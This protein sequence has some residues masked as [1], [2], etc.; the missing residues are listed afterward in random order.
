M[1]ELIEDRIKYGLHEYGDNP[2][3]FSHMPHWLIY[4]LSDGTIK[5]KFGSED[6]WYLLVRTPTGDVMVGPDDYLVRGE[7]GNVLVEKANNS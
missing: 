5:P 3:T 6:Y 2:L 1:E 4:A 7:K